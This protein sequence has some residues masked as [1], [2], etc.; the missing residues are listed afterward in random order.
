MSTN[1]QNTKLN[2]PK[3]CTRKENINRNIKY[4]RRETAYVPQEFVKT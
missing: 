2:H 3:R 4:A 1:Q